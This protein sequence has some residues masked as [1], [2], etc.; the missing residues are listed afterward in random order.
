M[1]ERFQTARKLYTGAFVSYLVG[2]PFGIPQIVSAVYSL[3]MVRRGFIKEHKS[4]VLGLAITEIVIYLAA[5]S[6]VWY[7]H[8]DCYNSC[9]R[10]NPYYPYDCLEHRED[11]YVKYYGFISIIVW[12]CIGILLGT[13]RI[14]LTRTMDGVSDAKEPIQQR[15]LYAD[16]AKFSMILSFL[17]I[18]AVVSP[19]VTL[20][21]KYKKLITDKGHYMAIAAVLEILFWIVSV[22]L[23][24]CGLPLLM[25]I[26][27]PAGL[28]FGVP[29]TLMLLRECSSDQLETDPERLGLLKVTLDSSVEAM[30]LESQMPKLLLLGVK[31]VREVVEMDFGQMQKKAGFTPEEYLRVLQFKRNK[32]NLI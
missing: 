27:V 5:L 6:M 10:S 8:R 28:V 23:L 17:F 16:E 7:F 14:I 25:T 11:C 30:V 22:I 15:L 21:M 29:R 4:A 12:A 18:P 1:S 3:H 32:F 31:T 24:I 19:V 13:P 9:I 20:M 2:I 26:Y